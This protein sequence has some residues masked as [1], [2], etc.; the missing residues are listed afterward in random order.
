MNNT[1]YQ[2]HISLE[3]YYH[4][5]DHDHIPLDK[6]R[7]YCHNEDDYIR[8]ILIQKYILTQFKIDKKYFARQFNIDFDSYFKREIANLEQYEKDGLVDLNDP[9]II[10]ITGRGQFFCRHV[11]QVFDTFYAK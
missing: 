10:R 6:N 1:F 11:A 3:E 4:Q 9:E 8:N 5:V 2:N 7:S